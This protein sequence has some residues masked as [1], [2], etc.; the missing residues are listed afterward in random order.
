MTAS[1]TDVSTGGGHAGATTRP[2][3]FV[4]LMGSGKSTIG[5]RVANRLGRPFVD[6][7]GEIE[8]R[9]GATIAELF[10]RDGEPA[11]R[12]LE[13]DVVAELLA[14]DDG[15]VISCGGGA[16]L[17]D[18]TRQRLRERAVVVWLRARASTLA[19]RT[20]PDGRRPLLTGDHRA[21][22]ERLVLERDPLYAEVADHIVDVDLVDRRAVLASVLDV[23]GPD[24]GGRP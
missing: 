7:D 19:H 22:L 5:R 10:A 17:D 11:F 3:A 8:A 23:L 14:R 2:I 21:T 12:S 13:A 1:D 4:G 16:V 20:A 24:G 15:A 9:T 18:G 6:V